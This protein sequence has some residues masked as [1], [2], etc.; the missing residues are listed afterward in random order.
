MKKLDKVIAREKTG[1]KAIRIYTGKLMKEI[2]SSKERGENPHLYVQKTYNEKRHCVEIQVVLM[3]E[4]HIEP[5][6]YFVTDPKIWRSFGE[7][8]LSIEDADRFADKLKKI[9]HVPIKEAKEIIKVMKAMTVEMPL[10][11]AKRVLVTFWKP[12]AC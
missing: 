5:L 4:H 8:V 11:K 10:R 3:G 9:I 1:A 12:R 6:S 2:D 7:I